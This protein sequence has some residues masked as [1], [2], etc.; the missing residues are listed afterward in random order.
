VSTSSQAGHTDDAGSVA[1]YLRGRRMCQARERKPLEEPTSSLSETVLQTPN[2]GSEE[3]SARLPN[4]SL[5]PVLGITT[6]LKCSVWAVF[7]RSPNSLLALSRYI[8]P[9]GEITAVGYEAASVEAVGKYHD[10]GREGSPCD[11]SVSKDPVGNRVVAV[12][13]VNA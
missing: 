13:N 6:Y 11:V 10:E 9:R 3:D 5:C 1:E 8:T 7:A 4:G 12:P 2:I